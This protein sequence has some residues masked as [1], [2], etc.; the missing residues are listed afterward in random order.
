MSKIFKILL[1]LITLAFASGIALAWDE[2]TVA[3]PDGN[4]ERP[5]HVGTTGQEKRG[6]LTLTREGG[7]VDALRLYDTNAGGWAGLRGPTG[8][9]ASYSLILPNSLGTAG[10]FLKL[11]SVSG[12]VGTLS[13]ATVSGG[14]PVLDP[15]GVVF[16]NSSGNLAVDNS[17]LYWK[18]NKLSVG[19]NQNTLGALTVDARSVS[20]SIGLGIFTGGQDAIVVKNAANNGYN[21][22]LTNPGQLL[23][24]NIGSP[25]GGGILQADGNILPFQNNT[26]NLG[27]TEHAWNK[28]FLNLTTGSIPFVAADR[29][30]T[31]KNDQLFWDNTNNR[32]GVGTNAPQTALDVYGDLLITSPD[33]PSGGSLFLGATDLPVLH[34]DTGSAN[35]FLGYATA[36]GQSSDVANT[37]GVGD[38]ALSSLTEGGTTVAVGV[39]ALWSA[40]EAYNSIAVGY[41]SLS[42]F[43]SVSSFNTAIG[44]Q[45]MGSTLGGSN[46]TAIGGY[47]LKFLNNGS[48]NVAFG[49][50]SGAN[51]FN[52]D[53]NIYIGVAAGKDDQNGDDN[54]MIGYKSGN[55]NTGS[56]NLFIGSGAM[57]ATAGTDTTESN[58]L[59][60]DY[61]PS[62]TGDS[63][64]NALVFGK[65]RNDSAGPYVRINGALAA[66]DNS[67]ANF[68]G[69]PTAS[70][71]NKGGLYGQSYH[72]YNDASGTNRYYKGITNKV[73]SHNPAV[74]TQWQVSHFVNGVLVCQ[75]VGTTATVCN[76]SLATCCT[77]QT[78]GCLE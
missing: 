74:S 49:Y 59:V 37:V 23:L 27:D 28:I 62:F 29:S 40:D 48:D 1:T 47:A 20:G 22:R 42:S 72:A 18:D 6:T 61:N 35:L 76:N 50:D 33:F 15:Y 5:I 24:G 63:Y 2:P 30:L 12:G 44:S 38:Y 16:T 53:R 75:N 14:S 55:K 57:S 9:A 67:V 13:F 70:G 8:A 54:V 56:G 17:V 43:S 41:Q 31:Q 45:A 10:Q 65:F 34:N 26:W 4:R 46:N 21:M 71:I 3:P 73:C 32:L 25:L 69:F 39:Y 60:L 36:V 78:G 64:K 58:T 51:A 11:N 19:S 7:G 52:G 66:V 77:N 68:S